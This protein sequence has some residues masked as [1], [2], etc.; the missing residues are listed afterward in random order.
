MLRAELGFTR[1]EFALEVAL[2]ATAG[3]TLVLIG[4]SGCGKTCCRNG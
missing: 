3:E 2:D 4:E 1:G